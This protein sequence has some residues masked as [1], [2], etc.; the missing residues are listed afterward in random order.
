MNL[1]LVESAFLE[2]TGQRLRYEPEEKI[3]VV[4]VESF[5]ELGRLTG[6]RFLEWVSSHPEGVVALPTGRTPHFFMLEVRRLLAGWDDMDVQKE[7]GDFGLGGLPKPNLRGLHFCQ[8]DEF[9]PINPRHQNSFAYYVQRYYIRDFGLDPGKALL[10]NCEEIGLPA[11]M[12][13]E[14]VWRDREVD[15]SLRFRSPKSRIEEIQKGVLSSVDQWCSEYE[16]RIRELGGVQFFLGGI[17]P[18]GHIGFNVRGSDL[19]STTR[20]AEINYETQAAAAIDL[21]GMETVRKS[22]VITMGLATIT[23]N[24]DCVAIVM[25]AGEA[26]SQVVADG[27]QNKRHVLYPASA[28]TSLPCSRFY[29]TRGAGKNLQTRRCMV[30][31]QEKTLPQTEIEGIV[32]DLAIQHKKPVHELTREDFETSAYGKLILHRSEIDPI[33]AAKDTSTTL[34]ERLELGVNTLKNNVFLHT[35]PHHDDIMLGYLPFVVRHI[36][37]WSNR[38]TFAALTSGFTSVTNR[39]MLEK[40]RSLKRFLS[41]RAFRRLVDEGYYDSGNL[42]DRNRDVWQYLD[43]VAGHS[44]HLREEGEMRRL[45]RDL[46]EVFDEKDPTQLGDRTAELISYFETQYPGRKDLSHIQRLKG[47]T[48]E[49]ESDCLWGYFG[50]N[51]DSVHHLRLG[52]YQGDLFTDEPTMSRDVM[53]ILKLLR[54]ERPSVITVALDPEASGPDTHYKVMQAMSEALREYEKDH[55]DPKPVVLGYRNVW[56]RF[57]PS[58]A[59]LFVPVSLN[60]FS[61]QHDA[62]RNSFISQKDASFPSY[63]HA[64]PFSE[65]AQRIQVEQ[66]QTLKICLGRAFF[67][68]HS[69]ALVRATRGMVFLKKMSLEEFY[70]HSR[71]IRKST[72][73][74]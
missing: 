49:W 43:G 25:A 58:E 28:L 34:R 13:L 31:N 12:T 68:E 45:A 33:Q 42:V 30:L 62:F 74:G 24:K 46:I 21:G 66:Y 2:K 16:D 40:L 32:I 5:P 54:A 23:G 38:H 65:L 14:E 47:L 19:H 36:R 18:D 71:D 17:G 51:A 64:G 55:P 29:I 7:L 9:Y 11:G 22:K 60:M 73:D 15:L 8:I 26:K 41:S 57:H 44:P 50:W 53:P 35:E 72:E 63:E 1:S 3:G 39:Y 20:L 69:S 56:Y 4:V 52:F 67:Y 61:L 37:E 48:R 59:N 27:I 10:I 70:D 6:L